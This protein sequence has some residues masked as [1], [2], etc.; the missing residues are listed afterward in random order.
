[1]FK[2]W[3]WFERSLLAINI[4]LS[5]YFLVSASTYDWL[6]W[7]GFI[8][9]ITNTICV[10]LTAKKKV[11]NFLFGVIGVVCYTILAFAYANTGEWML[12]LFYY[13]PMNIIAWVKWYRH[14][15]DKVNVVSK[16][17][18]WK[19][20][21]ITSAIGAVAVVA[22]AWFISLPE[23]QLFFYKELT[24]FTFQKYLIDSFNVVGSI[25][26]MIILVKQ[27]REQWILWIAVDIMTIILWI[28]TFDPIMIVMWS[29]MLINAVYGYIKWLKVEKAY[30]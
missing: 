17:M 9:S 12:N 20:I 13:M 4:V 22:Y 28:I 3:N 19:Q 1:M 26:G 14:S 24:G 15:A 6:S 25:I 8:A 16:A 21:L 18:T 30:V 23:L 10:I 5:T 2:N 29:T 7:L 27:Y 11:I